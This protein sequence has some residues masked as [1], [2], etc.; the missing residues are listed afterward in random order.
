[1]IASCKYGFGQ[2]IANLHPDNKIEALKWFYATQISYKASINLT[3]CSIILLF[4][5]IFGKVRW[6]RWTCFV[7][8]TIIALYAAG[9]VT[10]TV[11]QCSPVEFAWNKS[12]KDGYCF[13][14]IRF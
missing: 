9:S 1:M 14:I 4:H 12:I 3:K 5:R 8:T 6:V 2:H 11:I 10:A 7:L 13:A